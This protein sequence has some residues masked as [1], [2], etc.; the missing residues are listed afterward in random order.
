[1]VRGDDFISSGSWCALV[2]LMT[3]LEA[4]FDLKTTVVGRGA[5]DAREGC[6]LNSIIRVAADGWA[7]E[8]DQRHAEGIVQALNLTK[9]NPVATLEKTRRRRRRNS[10]TCTKT[11]Y[12]DSGSWWQEQ[13]ISSSTSPTF[14]MR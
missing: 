6:V 8:D 4:R 1:M 7:Y 5:S 3:L 9:A 13:K 11:R 12:L 10:C 2:W 14:S